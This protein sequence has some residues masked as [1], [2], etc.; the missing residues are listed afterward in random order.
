M[1]VELNLA[2]IPVIQKRLIKECNSKGKPVVTATQ[3]LES[4]ISS[5]LPTRAEVT[6]VANAIFD[7]TDAIMLSAETSIGQYPVESVTVMAEVAIETEAALPYA[8]MIVDK[9]RQLEPHVDDAISYD[10]CQ[11]AQ[12][13]NAALIVAFTESGATAA[14]VSK[15]RPMPS[16]MALTPSRKVER[17]L[18][19]NWGVTPVTIPQL[20][21]VDD[22]FDRGEDMAKTVAGVLPGSVVVL[23]AGLPIGVSGGT[24]LLRVLTVTAQKHV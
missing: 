13:L 5:S 20:K 15:Y 7:G 8:Q 21:S 4:M 17:R 12:Q 3:M 24:N 11:T 6:D 16:V 9:R 14:R 18:T 1:G 10:A 2:Q 23:V 19:I 22:F